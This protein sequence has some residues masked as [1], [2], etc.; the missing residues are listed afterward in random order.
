MFVKVKDYNRN[1]KEIVINLI[2]IDHIEDQITKEVHCK[3][4]KYHKVETGDYCY[5]IDHSTYL[6]IIKFMG[7]D[8]I[9]LT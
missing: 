2:K 8:Y 5:Y 1:G 6:Q 4:G 7:D 9:D 3:K